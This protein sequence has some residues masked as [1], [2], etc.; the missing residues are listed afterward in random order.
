M[1]GQISFASVI[2]HPHEAKLLDIDT[3]GFTTS[4]VLH[5]QLSGGGM[6]PFYLV[7]EFS[8][9]DTIRCV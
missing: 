1:S 2:S 9:T 6:L 7:Y 8:K 3:T 5:V 4:A